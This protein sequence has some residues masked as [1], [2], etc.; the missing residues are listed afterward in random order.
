[1]GVV[2]VRLIKANNL[3]DADF[4]GKTDP[5]VKLEL[6]QDNVVSNNIRATPFP[7]IVRVGGCSRLRNG[8]DSIACTPWW[9]QNPSGS[10][11]HFNLPRLS[12]SIT[13]D[14]FGEFFRVFS[15]S[16]MKKKGAS[17]R[18]NHRLWLLFLCL[19]W[20]TTAMCRTL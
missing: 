8:S 13:E 7:D 17:C 2:T 19:L 15:P 1:M 16:S 18:S 14:S 3:K 5:Y 4:M 11:N 12:L 6:E 9:N 20:S 10:V